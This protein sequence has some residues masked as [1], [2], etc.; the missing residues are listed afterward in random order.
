MNRLALKNFNVDPDLYIKAA[1]SFLCKTGGNL[2]DVAQYLE[3]VLECPAT[4]SEKKR[5]GK[6]TNLENIICLTYIIIT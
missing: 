1:R 3:K 4:T 2:T 6:K 5:K